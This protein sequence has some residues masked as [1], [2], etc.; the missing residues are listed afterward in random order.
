M[1]KVNMRCVM[2]REICMLCKRECGVNRKKTL[3][4]CNAPYGIKIARAALYFD[5][6]PSISGTS[7]SGAIF[8]SCCPLKC[9]FCQNDEIS[10][11]NFGEEI[12]VLRLVE[13]FF[14]LEK[15]GAIN[16]NLV[17]PTPYIPWIKE[18]I[19]LAKE[20]GFSLPFVYNSSGYEKKESLAEL[21]G[22]IDIYLPDFKYYDNQ[23]AKEFSN[24]IDYV[25]TAKETLSEMFR[26]T[27]RN[28]FDQNGIMTKGVLV[29]HLILPFKEEESKKIISYLY[30]TYHD[31]IYMSIMNQYTPLGNVKDHPLL[32]EKI[33]PIVYQEVVRFA[34]ELGVINAYI[35]EGDT[36]DTCY[37]P[38]FHL[39]GVK[40]E[41]N[42]I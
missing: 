12:S 21:E 34:E 9:I 6:E 14:E 32:K 35:Q 41:E 40:K 39:E 7:G 2:K 36:S 33:S 17:S 5:E 28:Q 3:G 1:L 23:T 16:I 24:C 30:H 26:Q 27:G 37:I 15:Q 31:D 22:L 42:L 29:R 10:L 8:F 20:K 18:A 19:L 38:S 4:F 11:K 25:E 13:I